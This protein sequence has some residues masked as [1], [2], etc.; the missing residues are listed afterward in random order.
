MN[1]S[2]TAED[3]VIPEPLAALLFQV[4]LILFLNPRHDATLHYMYV[5]KGS[6]VPTWN[7]RRRRGSFQLHCNPFLTESDAK[8]RP[9]SD[10]WLA[11]RDGVA[12]FIRSFPQTIIGM[13]A[14]AASVLHR[15]VKI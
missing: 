8:P 13:L 1:S 3:E 7:Y 14:R 15:I 5:F 12:A 6:A 4:W 11:G 10:S 2:G 9:Q